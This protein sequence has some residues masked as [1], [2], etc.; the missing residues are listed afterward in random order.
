MK[1][2][3]IITILASALIFTACDDLIDPTTNFKEISQMQTDQ[4]LLKALVTAYRT[5]PSYY[6]NSDVVTDDAVPI[7][8]SDGYLKWLQVR[9][10][11]L[12]T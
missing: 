6:D 1:I 12:S 4:V 2:K 5:L 11:P 9:G 3:N 10:L 8:K 7:A